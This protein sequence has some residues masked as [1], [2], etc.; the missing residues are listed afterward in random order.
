MVSFITFKAG[1]RKS[2]IETFYSCIL[3]PNVTI[4]VQV[5][6]DIA[7]HANRGRTKYD[8]HEKHLR[9]PRLVKSELNIRYSRITAPK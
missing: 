1:S 7:F 5:G 6:K 2:L 4:C 8:L 9:G 3:L